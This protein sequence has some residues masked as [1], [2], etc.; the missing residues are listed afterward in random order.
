MAREGAVMTSSFISD[1]PRG[2]IDSELRARVYADLLNSLRLSVEHRDNPLPRGLTREV[3][4]RN[5]YRSLPAYRRRHELA[6]R[7]HLRFG[8]A[9]LAVPG[10]G[11]DPKDGELT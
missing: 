2:P 7:L 1:L 3:T 10:F 6:R 9:L 5:C 4:D 11:N 8:D